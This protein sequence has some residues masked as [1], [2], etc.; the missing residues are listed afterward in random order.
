MQNREY[1]DFSFK[2][3]C[4]TVPKNFVG[5]HF[6]VSEKFGYQKFYASERG[7][8]GFSVENF[9]SHS[10]KKFC[11]GTLRFF[12]KFRESQN[13]VH[14]KGISLN[15]VEKLLSRSADEIRWRTL[16]CFEKI[17]VSKIFKQRRGEASRFCQNFLISQDRKKLRQGSILCCSK[18]LVRKNVS[19]IKGGG[20]SRC[21]V[22]KFL[23]DCS[24]VFHSRTLWRFGN[25][26]LSGDHDFV[27]FFCPTRTKRKSLWRNPSVFEKISGIEKNLWTRRGIS[28]FSVEIFIF[29]LSAEKF[30]KGILLSLKKL[31]FSKSFMDETGGYHVFPTNIFGLNAQKLRGHSFNVSENLGYRKF[32]CI[33]E[34]ITFFRRNFLVSQC[35]IF[36]RESLQCFRKFEV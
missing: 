34:G 7:V 25:L 21:S 22:E 5:E 3:F 26:L 33:I 16:R 17:P 2:I 36:S 24:K 8:S 11:R 4:L 1:H 32:L 12:R 13:F 31:L 27:E 35:R 30:G 19:R 15:S 6:G 9:V 28:R 20:V 10:T 29:S 23:S 14:K 18:I